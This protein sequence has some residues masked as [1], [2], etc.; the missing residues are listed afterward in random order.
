MA[1]FTGLKR[2]TYWIMAAN[3]TYG[4]AHTVDNIVQATA[5][6]NTATGSLYADDKKKATATSLNSKTL[7]LILASL[8]LQD[9][10]NI[11]GHEYVNGGIVVKDTDIAPYI[12]VAYERTKDDG[13]SEL[14][15]MYK[16]RFNEPTESAVTK[17][18]SINYQTLTT[19][20]EFIYDDAG[21]LEYK[22]D[23]GDVNT[24]ATQVANWYV[25]PQKAI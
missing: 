24:D 11:L 20:G 7:E 6:A 14:K 16:G 3:G 1:Y 8:P 21:F 22:V 19:S 18:D 9:Q 4:T 2:F 5:T 15:V 10:A 17:N 12:A 25:T 23:T 13:K